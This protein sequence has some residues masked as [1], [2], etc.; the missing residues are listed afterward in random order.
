M[1]HRFICDLRAADASRESA[2]P[3]K[4]FSG[5]HRASITPYEV[6]A[7]YPNRIRRPFR[8]RGVPYTLVAVNTRPTGKFNEAQVS[9]A[10]TGFAGS[11]GTAATQ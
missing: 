3:A 4:S 7:V 11:D 8:A 2:G 9:R 1:V 10:I 5:A 6:S